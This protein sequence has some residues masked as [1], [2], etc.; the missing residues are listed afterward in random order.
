MACVNLSDICVVTRPAAA[1]KPSE[2]FTVCM[3]AG[4]T[5]GCCDQCHFYHQLCICSIPAPCFDLV[6]IMWFSCT[7]A[8]HVNIDSSESNEYMPGYTV[9]LYNSSR[10]CE[11]YITP[12]CGALKSLDQCQVDGTDAWLASL[13]PHKDGDSTVATAAGVA[14]GWLHGCRVG[15]ETLVTAVG[16]LQQAS[17]CCV[18]AVCHRANGRIWML[19]GCCAPG[20][21]V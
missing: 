21:S 9:R 5:L 10:I 6:S 4:K 13:Q 15:H 17:L 16:N 18:M 11:T 19:I 3:G 8:L 12:A 1:L 2:A 14:S 20:S 7:A